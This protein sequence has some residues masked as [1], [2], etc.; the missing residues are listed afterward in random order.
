MAEIKDIRGRE[1]LDSRGNPTLEVEVI[2]TTGV[3]GRAS[4]PSGASTGSKEA[5]ELR[6]GEARY[7]GRGVQKA[8]SNIHNEIRAALIGHD[9]RHQKGIDDLLNTLDN[10]T[11]KGRL[12]A[13]TLLAISLAVAHAAALAVKM[14]LFEYLGCKEST[15][16]MIPVPLLNIIN[17][18]AHADNG[19]DIQEF[20]V[21]PAGAPNYR[22][23]L[24]FGAEIYHALKSILKKEGLSTGVG[25][26]GGFA[27]K[28]TSNTA[29]IEYILKAIESTGLQ[30][31]RDVYLGL[32]LA[33]NEFYENNKYVLRSEQKT[34]TPE[35]WLEYLS[36][37]VKQYPIV[38]LEDAM[39]E[40]DWQGWKALTLKLGETV[41]LVGDDVF[42]TNPQ[43]LSQGI[44]EKIANAILIKPNQIG[45]LT[46]TLATVH[47]AKE[48]NYA[49]VI[50]HRSAETEDTTIADLA[51]AARIPQIKT[52]APCRGERVAK[53]NQLLR[54]EEQLGKTAQY[55]GKKAF[56][57]KI[58]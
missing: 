30:S 23:A 49:T 52:G 42:V 27:P 2:L 45:T 6:D 41:Q 58:A 4:V 56:L 35:E 14:P 28:L 40:N 50:S 26:E 16:M 5:L 38:S 1:I 8:I 55:A 11:N 44:Q 19:L 34:F 46:E 29:A 31:G 48:A 53:Y 25:D 21:I 36:N 17:G 13:N 37:L 15:P 39:A 7:Q 32:D 43:I 22:E 18:G 3:V 24:R 9:V 10:T 47:M 20:M 51:V 57:G 54:I 33:S 12:G